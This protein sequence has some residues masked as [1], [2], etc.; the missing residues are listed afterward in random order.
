VVVV[1]FEFVHEKNTDPATFRMLVE[2]IC[3]LHL[4]N[5]DVDK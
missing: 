4:D 3:V 1:G 5:L 2:K